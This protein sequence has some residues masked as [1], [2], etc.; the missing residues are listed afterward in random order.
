MPWGRAHL[1]VSV[2]PS[3]LER[4]R[5]ELA[6]LEAAAVARRARAARMLRYGSLAV[7]AS[8]LF[9][10]RGDLTYAFAPTQPLELGG[11]LEF[12]LDREQTER[13]AHVTGVPGGQAAN[14]SHM[15]KQLRAFGLLGSNVLVVQDLSKVEDRSAPARG[16]P[17]AVSGRLQRDDDAVQLRNIFRLLESSGILAPQ[18]GHCYAL[19]AGEAPRG[20][21]ALPL[22]LLG[23]VLFV[24]INFRA[25]ARMARPVA[26]LEP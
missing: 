26:P 19:W 12:N 22:E 23:I 17:F 8:F 10:L 11:P 3:E 13:F 1:G 21:W 14:V 24:G 18:E 16:E 2:E 4:T 20:S 15:G 5:E 9:L 25:A 7:A 6:A